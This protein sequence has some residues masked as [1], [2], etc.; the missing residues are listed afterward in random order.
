MDAKIYFKIIYYF[1]NIFIISN[2]I[3]LNFKILFMKTK[4]NIQ[5]IKIDF[6]IF[7]FFKIYFSYLKSYHLKFQNIIHKKKTKQTSNN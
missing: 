6:K 2:H 5:T 3:I 7:L 4:Q 1:S